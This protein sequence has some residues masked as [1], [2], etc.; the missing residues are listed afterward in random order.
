VCVHPDTLARFAARFAADPALDAVMGTYDDTPAA[1]NFLSQYKNLFHHYVHQHC[2][3][4]I[5]TFWSGCGAIRRPLFLTCGGFDAQRYRC[6]AIEDIE[7]G[8]RLH[9]AGYRIVLDRRITATHLKR[10]TLGSLLKTDIV[11]RGVPWV[12]LK[13]I[14]IPNAIFPGAGCGAARRDGS[15]LYCAG[16]R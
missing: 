6:P 2:D 11:N 14:G 12:R 4:S 3:G 9:A 13:Q 8:T 16:R 10:W 1:P 5:S 15:R 7:L